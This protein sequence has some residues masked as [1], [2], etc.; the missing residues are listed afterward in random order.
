MAYKSTLFDRHG[1]AAGDIVKAW[2]Y[3]LTTFGL[4]LVMYTLIGAKML[5]I[6]GWALPFFILGM[7]A[8]SGF[9]VGKIGLIG[10]N[11]TGAVVHEVLMSGSGAPYQEQFSREQSL[12]M[13]RKVD[14]ALALFEARIAEPDSGVEVRLRA[15]E[16]YAREG[17]NPKRAA[18]LFREAQNH[19][20]CTSGSYAH[21]ANRLVDLLTGPL[22]DPGRGLGE[23]RRLIDRY[24]DSPAATHA[25]IALASLK[26]AAFEE[27]DQ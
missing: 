10:S 3:G 23:L 15:A 11:L 27:S 22:N 4:C 14:D 20:R 1:P 9:A 26:A 19:P 16:V 8:A 6:T 12:L 2:G 5:G 25:R 18:E 13:Q 21:A 24:P 17:N 7:S